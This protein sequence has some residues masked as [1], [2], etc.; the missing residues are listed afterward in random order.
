MEDIYP[1]HPPHSVPV[2][3]HVSNTTSSPIQEIRFNRKGDMSIAFSSAS[4]KDVSKKVESR[5]KRRGDG[6]VRGK[7]ATSSTSKSTSTATVANC[8]GASRALDAYISQFEG[9][10][11]GFA[12]FHSA[13]HTHSQAHVQINSLPCHNSSYSGG[14]SHH[15][16][17]RPLQDRSIID[18]KKK[19]IG[20]RE[21]HQRSTLKMSDP[22]LNYLGISPLPIIPS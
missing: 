19:A 17:D 13:N 15:R 4:V 6:G 10:G 16:S 8:E 11:W 21:R 14:N 9:S 7:D 1:T 20:E 22:I 12:L 2:P 5:A 3:I 18:V